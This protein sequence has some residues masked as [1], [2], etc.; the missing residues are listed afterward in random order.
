MRKIIL[1]RGIQGS[2]KSFFAK[3]W[4]LEDPDNRV[5]FNNDD[6][7]NMLGKYWMPAREGVVLA[8]KRAFLASA[9]S[10]GY[11]IVIDNMNLNPN[12][13]QFYI[14]FV[15]HHNNPQGVIPDAVREEYEIVFKD[16]PTPLEECIEKGFK[17]RE[18]NWREGYSADL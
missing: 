1:C 5:R 2:G 12:E 15:A 14:N 17:K 3:Q 7:R 8:M 4:V 10:F 13:V 11:D 18:S 6:I 9:M 16:F